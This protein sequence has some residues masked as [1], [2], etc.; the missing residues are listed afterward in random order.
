MGNPDPSF[1]PGVP[2]R[3]CPRRHGHGRRSTTTALGRVA[4]GLGGQAAAS[5]RHDLLRPHPPR[6]P[7][8][9]AGSHRAAPP[10]RRRPAGPAAAGV[11]AP[12]PQAP[13]RR[14]ARRAAAGDLHR[15]R[16]PAAGKQRPRTHHPRDEPHDRHAGAHGRFTTARHARIRHHVHRRSAGAD[17]SRPASPALRVVDP[18]AVDA[19]GRR[20]ARRRSGRGAR[21]VQRLRQRHAAGAPHHGPRLRRLRSQRGSPHRGRRHLPRPLRRQHPPRRRP[22]VDAE[23]RPAVRAHLPTAAAGLAGGREP[24]RLPVALSGRRVRRQPVGGAARQRRQ[25]RRRLP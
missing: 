24:P 3:A 21:L 11:R 16:T 7:R 19:E 2:R 23:R 5:D 9:P 6:S 25:R 12:R 14:E 22:P 18:G 8:R 20:P 13:A 1:V 15:H 17:G 10:R 4:A